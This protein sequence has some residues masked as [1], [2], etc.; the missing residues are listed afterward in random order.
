[1]LGV[2]WQLYKQEED[3][4]F[5][6]IM[7]G[8]AAT[9]TAFISRRKEQA[10]N[11]IMTTFEK[12]AQ[13]STQAATEVATAGA[14]YT[15]AARRDLIRRMS[16]HRLII[17]MTEAGTVAGEAHRTAIL[18][19]QD[20][21]KNT[22]ERVLAFIE[23]GD[24]SSARTLSRRIMEVARLPVSVSQGQM[25]AA[26]SDA[27]DRLVTPVSQAR[28]L[29]TLRNRARELDAMTKTW[30]TI[31]DEKVRPSHAAK[32]GET[33]PM[34]RLFVL[35]GGMMLQPRDGSLGASLSEVIACRC[36]LTYD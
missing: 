36:F 23:A 22:V 16:N 3:E 28:I 9:M 34:H 11:A 7:A 18:A 8:V 32:D 27:R 1:M 21:L 12:F 17:A 6:Q 14:E 30:N 20:P 19:V 4:I 26:I 5:E 10:S 24:Y 25:I 35:D 33:I 29:S 13:R 2:E 31:G 15:R